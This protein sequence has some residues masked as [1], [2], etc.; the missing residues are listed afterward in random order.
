MVGEWMRDGR[1]WAGQDFAFYAERIPGFFT[2]I[3]HSDE[4]QGCTA[5]NH[6]PQF[7]VQEDVLP[8]GVALHLTFAMEWLNEH[9]AAGKT[10]L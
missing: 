3:G 5:P 9:A 6:S 8:I 1:G 10:E 4:S 7:K 2:F